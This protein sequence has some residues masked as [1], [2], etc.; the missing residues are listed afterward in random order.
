MMDGK[1]R[2]DEDAVARVAG[3]Y[4]AIGVSLMEGAQELDHRLRSQ[5]TLRRLHELPDP[6][7]QVWALHLGQ[8]THMS[9]DESI[10]YVWRKFGKWMGP[11]SDNELLQ[12][13]LDQERAKR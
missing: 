8:T 12:M 7:L 5:Q 1:I 6:W 2:I 13:K 3:F 10:Y 11:V 4:R 9:T